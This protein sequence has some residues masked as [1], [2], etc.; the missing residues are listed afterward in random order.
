MLTHFVRNLPAKYPPIADATSSLKISQT[1]VAVPTFEA[2]TPAFS[3]GD[4]EDSPS[5]APNES[6]TSDKAAVTNPPAIT[7]AHDTPDSLR[8]LASNCPLVPIHSLDDF[9]AM[10]AMLI[11]S[12]LKPLDPTV[13][14]LLPA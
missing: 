14:K 3:H 5:P 2:V 11:F 8:P 4:I 13:S 10:S 1:I 12:Y 7:A 6:K 9:V